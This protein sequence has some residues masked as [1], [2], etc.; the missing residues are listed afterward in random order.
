MMCGITGTPGTGKSTAADELARRGHT[1]VHITDIAQPYVL[2]RDPERDTQVID[3]DRM[4]DEFVPFD[5]F[6]EG[7]FAHL[8]PCDRM[9]VMRLRPDELAAR[10]RA[11]GY[12]QDKIRE[13]RDAEALDVCL[14]E[15]VEQFS[16][17]QVFELDTTGKS[18]VVC[19]DLIEQFYLGEIPASFGS[20]DWSSYAEGSL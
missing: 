2:G 3:T 17:N 12:E 1:V 14:I 20:I 11:R 6:I 10:L 9:V 16:P 13:N 7:H 5:G 15:T 4:V 8:L 19:A 18:P